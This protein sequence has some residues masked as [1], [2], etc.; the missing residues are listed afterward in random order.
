MRGAW[1]NLRDYSYPNGSTAVTVVSAAERLKRF[2]RNVER[3]EMALKEGVTRGEVVDFVPI[4]Y[5]P[6]N[7]KQLGEYVSVLVKLDRRVSD[8]RGC[9]G[10]S[11]EY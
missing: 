10:E 8:L 9:S 11:E 5:P 1:L 4:A 7:L 6:E 2:A 3:E